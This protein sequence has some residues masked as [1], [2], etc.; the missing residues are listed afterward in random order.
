MSRP[1]RQITNRESTDWSDVAEW[2]DQLVGDRGS[3]Y[4]RRVIFPNVLRLLAPQPNEPILDLACGQGAFCRIL[5]QHGARATGIDAS[6]QLI[7]LARRRSAS[8]AS[9]GAASA[10]AQPLPQY[11]IADA[12]NLG[13]LTPSGFSAVVCIL[14][15]QNIDTLPPVFAGVHRALAPD[16]RFVIVMAHPCFRG[17]K[18]TTWAWDQSTK[19]QYRR[20]D[21]YLLPRK[22]PIFTHP[23]HKTGQYTWTFHRPLQTYVK[24]LRNAGLLIDALEEWPGHRTST[25]GPRAP[26][27]NSAR[28]EIPLFLALRALKLQTFSPQSLPNE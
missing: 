19:A 23:G 9:A 7:D 25:S 3:E 5:H 28:K 8:L 12:R 14:A 13:F 2:Y 15:I 27:E 6:P 10:A 22:H 20:I 4:Q 21:R 11:H 24:A 1:K 16:G 18:Y 26:A 17:P